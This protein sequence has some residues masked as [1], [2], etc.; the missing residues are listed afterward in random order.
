VIVIVAV[1]GG[2]PHL[3]RPAQGT[4]DAVFQPRL[5]DTLS[6]I[7]TVSFGHRLVDGL[8]DGRANS[9]AQT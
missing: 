1:K 9:L 8:V 2:S 3:E 7:L 4:P 6:M 5:R